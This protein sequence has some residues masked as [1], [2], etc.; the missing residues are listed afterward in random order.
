MIRVRIQLPV[1]TG[2]ASKAAP[3]QCA[4]VLFLDFASNKYSHL[5][6]NVSNLLLKIRRS[7]QNANGGPISH[8]FKWEII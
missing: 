6:L 8:Y 5:H 2:E 1:I 4:I 7:V 3:C